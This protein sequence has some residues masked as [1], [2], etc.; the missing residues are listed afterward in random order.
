MVTVTVRDA[1]LNLS[2]LLNLVERGEDVVIRNRAR[3]VARVSRYIETPR[4]SLP[5]LTSERARLA[6]RKSGGMKSA[7]VVRADRDGRG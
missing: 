4:V 6:G 2:K 1:R 3:P 7:A 5:D